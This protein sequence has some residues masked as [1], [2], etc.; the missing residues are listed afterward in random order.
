MPSL[1]FTSD[2]KMN[3]EKE[4]LKLKERYLAKYEKQKTKH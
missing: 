3:N 4:R 2:S 1:F